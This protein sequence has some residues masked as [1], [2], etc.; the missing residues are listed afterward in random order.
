VLEEGLEARWARHRANAEYLWSKLAALGLSLHVAA[1]HRLPS[2]TTVRA[3]EGVDEAAV[4]ARLRGEYN[5]EIAGGFGPLKGKIWRV[6]LMGFS[7]RR[8]NVALLS[9]ALREVLGR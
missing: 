2:L 3:P 5:I 8:E 9:E 7:S 1:E 4:R 6:G